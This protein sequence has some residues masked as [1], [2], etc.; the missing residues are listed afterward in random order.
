MNGIG[1]TS[2]FL[3]STV[4]KSV[5]NSEEVQYFN[6]A[7]QFSV[8]NKIYLASRRTYG[9]TANPVCLDTTPMQYLKYRSRS[10]RDGLEYFS[11][12]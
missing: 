5:S 11:L 1:F 12:Y 8:K 6:I 7:R 3:E 9:F 2:V 10:N 4:G